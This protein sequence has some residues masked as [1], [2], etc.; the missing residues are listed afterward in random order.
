MYGRATA[1]THQIYDDR[2]AGGEGRVMCSAIST[3]LK[4]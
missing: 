1:L 2:W 4:I 3:D